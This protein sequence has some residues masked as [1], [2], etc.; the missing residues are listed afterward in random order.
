MCLSRDEQRSHE[1]NGGAIDLVCSSDDGHE[2]EVLEAEL[3]TSREAAE[4]WKEQPM[5]GGKVVACESG[6]EAKRFVKRRTERSVTELERGCCGLPVEVS[7]TEGISIG[8]TVSWDMKVL[9]AIYVRSTR[10][11]MAVDY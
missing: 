7:N 9:P 1:L 2:R 11:L 5:P 10:V 8:G 4:S 3:R 6:A